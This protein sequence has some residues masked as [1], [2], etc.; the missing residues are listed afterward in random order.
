MFFTTKFKAI[1]MGKELDKEFKIYLSK[2][3]VTS[4]RIQVKK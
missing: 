1:R 2:E 3:T 4:K